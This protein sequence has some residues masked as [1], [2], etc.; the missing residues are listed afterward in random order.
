MTRAHEAG[1]YLWTQ[2]V[3]TVSSA[4]DQGGGHITPVVGATGQEQGLFWSWGSKFS[5]AGYGLLSISIRSSG[6]AVRVSLVVTRRPP[7]PTL[8]HFARVGMN[9]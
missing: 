3:S 5:S 6:F 1:L 8:L 2:H 4:A 9:K 7:V